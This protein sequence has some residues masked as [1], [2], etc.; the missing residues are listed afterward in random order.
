[1]RSA[2][3][4]N[5]LSGH[6]D[7]VVRD[8]RSLAAYGVSEKYETETFRLCGNSWRVAITPRGHY[9]QLSGK[10]TKTFCAIALINLSG[11]EVYCGY[12]ISLMNYNTGT[13]EKIFEDPEGY[14]T[15]G[16]TG[17]GYD[18]WGTEEFVGE[19]ELFA[20]DCCYVQ[21]NAL[22][23]RVEVYG[24]LDLNS[25]LLT[26]AIENDAAPAVLMSIAENEMRTIKEA[27]NVVN[28][29]SIVREEIEF[30]DNIVNFR[31]VQ[32]QEQRVRQEL[33]QGLGDGSPRSPLY[34]PHASPSQSHKPSMS[35]REGSRKS[36][37]A[38]GSARGSEDLR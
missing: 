33:Q 5:V 1:M 18:S 7:F 29:A 12:R 27:L 31:L 22:P 24:T 37:S 36:G 28:D 2:D 16:P 10:D 6:F 35:A 21:A 11:K 30:Q 17:S 15:F 8:W 34:S 13:L 19:R 3:S 9:E 14:V 23:V 4:S 38:R 25:N 32:Q 26:E 20:E